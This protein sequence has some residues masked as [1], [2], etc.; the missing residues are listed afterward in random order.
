LKRKIADFGASHIVLFS[1]L[2]ILLLLFQLLVEEP[3]KV[4]L[5]SEELEWQINDSCNVSSSGDHAGMGRSSASVGSDSGKRVEGVCRSQWFDVTAGTVLRFYYVGQFKESPD[6]YIRILLKNKD[7]AIAGKRLV[8]DEGNGWWRRFETLITEDDRV[9]IEF[10]TFGRQIVKSSMASRVDV[11]EFSLRLHS[12]RSAFM[13]SG[14]LPFLC[15]F[16]AVLVSM[17]ALSLGET[18]RFYI[19]CFVFLLFLTFFVQFRGEVYFHA[20]EW[21]FLRQLMEGG[22]FLRHNEHFVPLFSLFY[23]L[24]YLVFGGSYLGFVL[25]SI[26]LTA[27]NGCLIAY[28]LSL[29]GQNYISRG[30]VLILAGFYVINVSQTE[31]IQWALCQSSILSLG[32]ALASGIALHHYYETGSR[33]FLLFTVVCYIASCLS[34]ALGFVVIG[35][36]GL[37]WIYY[38]IRDRRICKRSFYGK[39]LL[40]LVVALFLGLLIVLILRQ[41]NPDGFMH[42]EIEDLKRLP[43][44]KYLGF[45]NSGSFYGTLL[46]GTGLYP[47]SD[48]Q[49]FYFLAPEISLEGFYHFRMRIGL[50]G[51]GVFL[52][53]LI[54]YCFCYKGAKRVW[55]VSMFVLSAAW[56]LLPMT[57]ISYGRA[58]LGDDNA[59][60]FRYQA[61]PMFGLMILLLPMYSTFSEWMKSKGALK[62]FSGI[63]L[64]GLFIA[65]MLYCQTTFA[66]FSEVGTEFRSYVR[67]YCEWSAGD[68]RVPAPLLYSPYLKAMMAPEISGE[69]LEKVVECERWR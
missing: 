50:V 29:L 60:A 36:L 32:F 15:L 14:A 52:L 17:A 69:E 61:F 38:G 59:M 48:V 57:M 65:S 35:F 33:T 3:G 68:R 67:R 45:I 54:A 26:V 34:F 23:W 31:L 43:L 63:A 5:G 19:Y 10:S 62:K 24:Q 53:F 12:L 21:L 27:I 42:Y 58:V 44:K 20:D 8:P 7:G 9:R 28:L 6:A 37:Q 41:L 47:W 1:L 46:R 66:H 40:Q 56:I 13:E 64:P 30:Y 49:R 4:Y 18:Q 25:S 51:L 55:A 11:L 39:Q 22:V 2:G 16:I